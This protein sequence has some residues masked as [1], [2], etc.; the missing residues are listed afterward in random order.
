MGKKAAVV[1]VIVMAITH[2]IKAQIYIANACEIT[3]FSPT[4]IEDIAAKNTV[5][6]PLLNVQTGDFQMKIPMISFIF[7]KPLMQE[8]FNE[9]FVETEKFPYCFFKGKIN[10]K[11]DVTKDG[12]YEVTSTGVLTIHGIDKERTITG[13]L[14]I[15]NA[16]ITLSS[17]F[18]ILFADHNIKIPALYSGIFPSDTE[19]KFTATLLP[20]KKN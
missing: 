5:T 3:F 14:T 15:K 20:Y 13:T 11:I 12:Q 16:E 17:K 1:F 8:H 2:L 4:S 10:E 19:V 9:N 7:D 6:K 18:N